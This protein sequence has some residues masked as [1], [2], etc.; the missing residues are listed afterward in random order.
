M[1]S[2]LVRELVGEALEAI[3]DRNREADRVLD[4]ALRAHRE[5]SSEERAAV[6]RRTLG[7]ACL[8]ARLDFLLDHA[9]PGW[10][11]HASE[12]RIAAYALD[13]E[14][15]DPAGAADASG[16]REEAIAALTSPVRW[17]VDPIA[18]LAAE[19]SLPPWLAERFHRDFGDDADKLAAVLNRPGPT[20]LRANTL[21]AGRDEVRRFLAEEGIET[22]PTTLSPW[23]LQVVGRA[24]LFGSRSWRR[25]LFEVQDEGS[26]LVARHVGAQPGERV[27]DFCAGAGG[28]SLA[29]AA[30]MEDRGE[31]L[32]LDP[33]GRRLINLAARIKRSG[34]TLVRTRRLEPDRPLPRDL[35]LADRVLVDAPC[36]SL[37]TLRRSPDLR[38][39]IAPGSIE[40]LARTQSEI[41][42]RAGSCVR[43]GGRL[44][45]ATCTLGR[46]EN[47]E[48]VRAFLAIHH[49]YE[50]E[51][52]P[53]WLLP[54]VD[55]TDGFFA[56]ALRRFSA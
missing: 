15:L 55:G 34:A 25:G 28:K 32:A 27:I 18:R 46:E 51:G 20:V 6:A 22:L 54:H 19:R 48:V 40:S 21:A 30:M 33:D 44:V 26:Q 5:L 24:N 1:R 8:R 49:E 36:S 14:H 38:W 9:C 3:I 56:A 37:G 17:P 2:S 7:I 16:L 31:I 23:G 50:L 53:L 52:T 45:Y 29:L 10:R 13:E 42:E 43:P 4:R 39:R 41:L 11:A 35:G 47:D 12:F